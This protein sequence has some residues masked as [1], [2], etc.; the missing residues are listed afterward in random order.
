MLGI[1]KKNLMSEMYKGLTNAILRGET[2][3]S[4]IGKRIV[5]P[6]SFIGGAMYMF[7]NYQD[8]M[9]I[10]GWEPATKNDQ[11]HLEP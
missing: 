11:N 4:M 5:F 10:C 1:I 7:Q 6:S 2:N 8:T 9:T 3:P